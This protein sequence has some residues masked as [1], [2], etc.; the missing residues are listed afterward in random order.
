MELRLRIEA[1][2]IIVIFA[3]LA[4]LCIASSWSQSMI[5]DS[6][7]GSGSEEID[8]IL[9][10]HGKK[11]SDIT[12]GESLI[13]RF[14]YDPPVGEDPSLVPNAILSITAEYAYVG[15]ELRDA[16]IEVSSDLITW[17]DMKT[18]PFEDKDDGISK[19]IAPGEIIYVRTTA[20]SMTGASS[21]TIDIYTIL[22]QALSPETEVFSG[23]VG[24]G[25]YPYVVIPSP[26]V[27]LHSVWFEL[28]QGE[29][30]IFRYIS[31]SDDLWHFRVDLRYTG[32][33]IDL[34]ANTA[35]P[36]TKEEYS[37]V[38]TDGETL[39]GTLEEDNDVTV[40]VWYFGVYGENV[41]WPASTATTSFEVGYED[42]FEGVAGL[43]PALTLILG[44]I[45][46]LML[47]G[48]MRVTG[49]IG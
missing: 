48:L 31:P 5:N 13:C 12:I 10:D 45:G 4:T 36:P 44:C 16:V 3:S 15:D 1:W 49:V 38:E 9:Y 17:T 42:S 24:Q 18:L 32:H 33:D 26:L 21:L 20:I 11:R 8:C 41:I 14:R 22:W 7:A 47:T 28:P 25:F 40:G 29:M 46:L 19:P 39:T 34:Y 23:F 2:F 43:R 37:W 27:Y 6:I 35:T 30:Y